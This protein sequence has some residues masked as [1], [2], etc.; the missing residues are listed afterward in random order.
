MIVKPVFKFTEQELLRID[1]FVMRGGKLLCFIDNLYAEQD[2]LAFKPETIAFDRDLN[3]T[4]LF[5]R[6]GLRINTDLV[7]DLQCDKIPFVVGGT[8]ENPQFAFLPWNYYPF[9]SPAEGSFNKNMGYVAGRFVNSIDTIQ[10]A[11][12]RKTPLLVTSP[13]SRVISTPALI[14]L[15]ENKQVPADDK[16][17]SN[18]I[19]AGML[20]E[21][22]FTSLFR[23]RL[24]KS[25]SDSLAAA[26]DPFLQ[27]SP[28]NKMIIV[29]DG[30]IV[31]NEL[32]PGAGPGSQPEPL[33]MGWNR[34]TYSE[35]AK[36][37][38]QGRYFYSAANREFLLGCIEYLVNDPGISATKNKDII[39]RLLDTKKINEQRSTW[40]LINIAAPV[41]LLLIAGWVYQQVRKR[42]YAA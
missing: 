7:M 37:S 39:L 17:K 20:L 27:A 1:Q 35:Y 19:P 24:P 23:N 4:N 3:L 11:G 40:Q 34:F 36:Q 13:N 30:D 10:V 5:F 6:Y 25:I 21:G 31:L 42:K 41:L 16:F 33:P 12:V 14:S 15:N 8:Q 38:E 2:S 28:E 9:L 29:A 18:A 22:N 32:I 26:G